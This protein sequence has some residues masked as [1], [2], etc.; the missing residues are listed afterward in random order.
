MLFLLN[1][2]SLSF[3]LDVADS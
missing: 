3:E 1:L 2:P